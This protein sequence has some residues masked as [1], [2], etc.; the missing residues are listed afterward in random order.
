MPFKYSITLILLFMIL[1]FSRGFVLQHFSDLSQLSPFSVLHALAE[2][3]GGGGDGGGGD[4]GGSDGGGGDGGGGDGGG[5]D[6]GGGGG[7][8]GGGVVGAVDTTPSGYF[9]FAD[10]SILAGWAYDPDNVGTPLSVHLYKDGPAGTGTFVSAYTADAPRPDVNGVLGVPG[11]YGFS[12]LTPDSL[13][14]GVSHDL[15]IYAIDI[16]GG[17]NPSLIGSPR[18]IFCTIPPPPPPEAPTCTLSVSPLSVVAGN[19]STLSWTTNGA[20]TLSIDNSIGPVTPV[21]AGSISGS[22]SPGT[23]IIIGTATGPGG[24]ATCTATLTVTSPPPSTPTPAPT[25][26]P[27]SP[28]STPEEPAVPPPPPPPAPGAPVC[29]LSASPS[30]VSSGGTS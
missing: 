10:C 27:P 18:T 1:A 16:S 12:V 17:A 25:P 14:D 3:D 4:G 6:G 13:K 8:D 9:D 23:Y 2:G 20:T 11:N 5:G 28:P 30:S 7:G 15:Y 19:P 29:T 26:T 21:A 24:S 22:V